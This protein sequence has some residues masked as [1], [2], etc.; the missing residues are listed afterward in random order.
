[1]TDLDPTLIDSLAEST[2]AAVK[3]VRELSADQDRISR[4][5]TDLVTDGLAQLADGRLALPNR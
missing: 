4:L 1:V 5:I 2:A 3:R